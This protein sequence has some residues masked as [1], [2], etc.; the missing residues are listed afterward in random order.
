MVTA[1]F[2]ASKFISN[3]FIYSYL[4]VSKIK[5]SN[6]KK[7]LIA[8]GNSS[9]GSR[10]NSDFQGIIYFSTLHIIISFSVY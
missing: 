10:K 4:I 9:L 8:I 7:L 2:K 3:I 1:I 6:S 5:Q